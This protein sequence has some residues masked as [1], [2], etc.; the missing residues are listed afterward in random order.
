VRDEQY[1]MTGNLLG[2]GRWGGRLQGFAHDRQERRD[3]L[4]ISCLPSIDTV[5]LCVFSVCVG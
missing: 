3:F 1:R 4:L 5:R 2:L